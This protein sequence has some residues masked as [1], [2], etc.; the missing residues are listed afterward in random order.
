M[1]SEKDKPAG[2]PSIV[3]DDLTTSDETAET[4]DTAA[5]AG[6]PNALSTDVEADTAEDATGTSD[7]TPATAPPSGPTFTKKEKRFTAILFSVALFL[8]AAGGVT[9]G[10]MFYQDNTRQMC[11]TATTAETDA[12]TALATA[13]ADARALLDSLPA[14]PPHRWLC[15]L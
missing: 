4:E 3:N 9:G 14:M 12:Q 2:T 11:A 1:T 10:A 15:H 7:D 13:E 8:G 6:E 5:P